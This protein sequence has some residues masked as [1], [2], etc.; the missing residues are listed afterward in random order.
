MVTGGMCHASLGKVFDG[1]TGQSIRTPRAT[2]SGQSLSKLFLQAR[3]IPFFRHG[4]KPSI[5][6]L[7]LSAIFTLLLRRAHTESRQAI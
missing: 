6:F 7:R 2:V 3:W 5:I 4:H 1:D